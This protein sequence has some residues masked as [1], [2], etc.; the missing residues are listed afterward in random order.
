[1]T[2]VVGLSGAACSGK[3]TLAEELA[4]KLNAVVVKEVARE[5]FSESYSRYG[6]LAE[7]RK[8][9]EKYCDFQLDVLREQVR[10][11]D[12]ATNAAKKA[13]KS[14]V[15]D[16]T[17]YDN[18]AYTLLWCKK[19]DFLE[20]YFEEFRRYEQTRRY[21]VIFLCHPL[22]PVED[23]F[24]ADLYQQQVEYALL[25]DLLPGYVEV[26]ATPLQK[27]VE[28]VLEHLKKVDAPPHATRRPHPQWW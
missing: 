23:G 18:L 25:T 19:Q 21:D 15:T 6:S 24:R 22:P 26:P 1:M 4:R 5:V 14:V 17:I 16:R 7:L 28:I 20:T 8:R 12:E 27:R 11:E 13:G 2:V 9:E 3:T 10:R